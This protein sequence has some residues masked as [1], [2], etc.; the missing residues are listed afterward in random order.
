MIN[1]PLYDEL[2]LDLT[3][4]SYS[5]ESWMHIIGVYH[6]HSWF[7]SVSDMAG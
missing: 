2:C 6:V 3:F 1:C 5:Y 7:I 4:F